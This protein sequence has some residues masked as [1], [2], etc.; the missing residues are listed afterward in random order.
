MNIVASIKLQCVLFLS[1]LVYMHLAIGINEQCDV[2][3]VTCIWYVAFYKPEVFASLIAAL[4]PRAANL[5]VAR[6]SGL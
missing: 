3:N 4:V 2:K 6:T 5:R 1:A